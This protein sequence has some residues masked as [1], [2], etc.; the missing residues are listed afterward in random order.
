[1]AE[2]ANPADP[3]ERVLSSPL[4]PAGLLALVVC[5]DLVLA[6]RSWSLLPN[7][8]LDETGHLATAA[9]VLLATLG[10]RRC[11]RHAAAAVA[12]L[13]ASVLI[14]ADHIPLYL[15]VPHV[16]AQ[17]RPYSHSLV[18]P[19]LLLLASALVRRWRPV[20]AGAAGG[21]LLHFVRDIG[22]GPGLP[23]HWPLAADSVLVP[24]LAYLAVVV[25]A[26]A[27]ATARAVRDR[28]GVSALRESSP[29]TIP[30]SPS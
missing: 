13:A 15:G 16:A 21:V 18:T 30:L 12:A 17:G 7:G 11:R 4:L 27:L 26:A 2:P 5:V 9:L 28:H 29:A 14:D 22:T 1:M 25:L 19:V 24:Y 8:L 3:A 10:W 6:A 23:L 20:L